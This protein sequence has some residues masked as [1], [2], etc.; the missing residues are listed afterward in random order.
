MLV[1]T[2][3]FAQS[4]EQAIRENRK[5]ME[6]KAAQGETFERLPYD[7]KWFVKT[8]IDAVESKDSALFMELVHSSATRCMNPENVLKMIYPISKDTRFLIRPLTVP[9]LM[10]AYQSAKEHGFTFPV[11]PTHQLAIVH[12]LSLKNSLF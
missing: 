6:E 12:R 10:E 8:Y 1:S 2:E 11:R 7:Q 5:N 9:E 3:L 4:A